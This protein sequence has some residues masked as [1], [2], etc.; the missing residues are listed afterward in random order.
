MF[1]WCVHGGVVCSETT[2]GK[3]RVTRSS[4]SGPNECSR[5]AFRRTSFV[6]RAFCDGPMCWVMVSLVPF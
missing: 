1:V 5:L 3:H 2:I 6:G 4:L